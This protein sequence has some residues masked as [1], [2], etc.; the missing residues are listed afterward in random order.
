MGLGKTIQTISLFSYIM[1]FKMNH[2]PF[3]IVVPLT[4]LPNWNSEFEKWAPSIKRIVYRGSQAER[5]EIYRQLKTTK[6]HVCIT[7]FDFVLKDRYKLNKF[8]WKYIVIDEGHR[9]KNAKCK[10]VS[11]LV[12]DY[13]SDHRLLLTGTPLQNNLS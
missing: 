10:F 4:T 3:L 5:N 13:A 12:H 11:V 9:I 8:E 2:G 7:T 6:W 1:E